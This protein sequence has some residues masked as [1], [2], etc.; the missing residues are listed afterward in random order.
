M[1][2]NIEILQKAYA[3][4]ESIAS[5]DFGRI[6]A[7]ELFDKITSCSTEDQYSAL[8]EEFEVDWLEH[9]E[10]SSWH[11][12]IE[13]LNNDMCSIEIFTNNV[14]TELNIGAK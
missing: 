14:L 11:H 1:N 8:I 5:Y 9:L 12:I 13:L 3:I 2:E 4:G 6:T 10:Y 7:A